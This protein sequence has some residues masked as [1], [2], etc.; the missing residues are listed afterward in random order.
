[1][2]LT[3]PYA[4]PPPPTERLPGCQATCLR[5]LPST[6]ARLYQHCD[7]NRCSSVLH[8]TVPLA[9]S[10]QVAQFTGCVSEHTAYRLNSITL[11][12]RLPSA[13]SFFKL[14]VAM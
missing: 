9:P 7:C 11:P 8:C 2:P 10:P 12:M 14:S 6:M 13:K 5:M 3:H 4:A 1:M